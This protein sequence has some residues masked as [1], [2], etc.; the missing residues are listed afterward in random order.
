MRLAVQDSNHIRL[1]PTDRFD[2]FKQISWWDQEKLRKARFLVIGA[3]AL[4]NEILK[5][6]AL[7]GVGNIF[8][9]DLDIVEDSNLSRSILY[10]ERDRGRPK[11]EVAAQVIKDIYPEI[12]AQAFQGDVI[13]E[14]GMG[15]YGWADVVV[16]GLDNREARLHVNRCCWKTNTPFIDGAT[17]N[18]QGVVRVFLPPE[19]PCYE[20]TMSEG[21]WEALKER[22]G[23]A[24]LQA[25]RPPINAVPTT[26]TTA[27]II[28]ALQCQEAIKLLH[29]IEGLAGKG[30][31][32]NSLVNDTYVIAYP[33]QQD[34]NSHETFTDI[35]RLDGSVY[36]LT[37]RAVLDQAVA[38]LGE[39][40]VLEFNHE[41][42][43]EFFCLECQQHSTVFRPLGSVPE[44]EA[45]CPRCDTE[46]RA[47]STQSVRGS[48][49]FLD[50]TFAELG[51]PPFDMIAARQRFS[52]IAFEFSGDAPSVMG[53]L[54]QPTTS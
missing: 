5:N 8:I 45:Q 14:L 26:P 17:E 37:V 24:G 15:V 54:H 22:R 7:L 12:S 34:C 10:R 11:A 4:G 44:R 18:L 31:V 47:I 32:F 21:D 29:Q 51:V 40:A 1:A 6:L 19:G 9:A 16:A 35:I 46:R 36:S 3:G 41:I 13:Y 28:A 43:I 49:A 23:C 38:R 33:S 42:L 2:R 27:S 20:C 48:E 53:A 52:T 39:G 30:L 25:E 50:R